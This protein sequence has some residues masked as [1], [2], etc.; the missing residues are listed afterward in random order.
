MEFNRLNLETSEAI[1]KLTAQL[2]QRWASL[3]NEREEL[4]AQ[5]YEQPTTKDNA[6]T[7]RSER[8][9]LDTD[10]TLPKHTDKADED[11]KV[12]NEK[13]MYEP[14]RDDK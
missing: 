13:N 9:L 1:H 4:P 14:A 3:E 8:L 11:T 5:V 2:E 6:L 7:K 10:K 12:G